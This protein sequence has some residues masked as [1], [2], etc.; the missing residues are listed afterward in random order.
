MHSLIVKSVAVLLIIGGSLFT[1]SSEL[2]AEQQNKCCSTLG[3]CCTCNG[4][5]SAGFFSCEC[6]GNSN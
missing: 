3:A 1:F 4:A 2:F 6:S 5:C